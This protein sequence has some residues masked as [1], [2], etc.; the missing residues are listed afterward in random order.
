MFKII[1]AM[2][3]ILAALADGREHH[4]ERNSFYVSSSLPAVTNSKWKV[5]CAS[6]HMLYPPALLPARSWTRLM[7]GL[8]KH[9]GENASLD[10]KTKDEITKFLTTNSAE[11]SSNRRGVK[12]NQS[13][14]PDSAPIR[15]TETPYFIHKHD[16]INISVWKRPKIKSPANCIACHQNAEQGVFSEHEVSIPR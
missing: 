6:C 8:D 5:E 16:E 9:F 13:M 7:G 2:T 4:G 15:I 12:I 3:V 14:T 10:A 1:L 11:N